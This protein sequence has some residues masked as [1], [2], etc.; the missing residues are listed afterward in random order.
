MGSTATNR[1]DVVAFESTVSA[2]DQ[3]VVCPI[4]ARDG[5]LDFWMIY[6]HNLVL[7]VVVSPIGNSY[8]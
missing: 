7:F 3:L 5:T 4:Y 6:V 1:Q 8:Y 2:C